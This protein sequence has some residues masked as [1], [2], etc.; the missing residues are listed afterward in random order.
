M[1]RESKVGSVGGRT[2]GGGAADAPTLANLAW[3]LRTTVRK[4]EKVLEQ[5]LAQAQRLMEEKH[6][7]LP[8]VF[9]TVLGRR[10]PTKPTT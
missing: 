1:D 4:L 7:L 10:N 3:T 6:E 9:Q 8:K 2:V 5:Q